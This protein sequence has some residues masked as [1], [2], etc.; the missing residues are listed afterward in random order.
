[1]LRLFLPMVIADR[2]YSDS[3]IMTHNGTIRVYARRATKQ[4]SMFC[5]NVRVF[6]F[7]K[8]ESFWCELYELI[9]FGEYLN[10]GYGELDYS[11]CNPIYETGVVFQIINSEG[12]C[13]RDYKCSN[14][15]ANTTGLF[16]LR[17]RPG[18]TDRIQLCIDSW[19]YRVIQFSWYCCR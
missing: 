3:Y 9:D 16:W 18:R 17:C 15:L 6:Q 5:V 11:I 1:M 8:G 2:Q 12:C 7:M 13:G 4:W 19:C 10:R 14:V